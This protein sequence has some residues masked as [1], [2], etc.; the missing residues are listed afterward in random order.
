MIQKTLCD[1]FFPYDFSFYCHWCTSFLSL[2][3]FPLASTLQDFGLWCWAGS[4]LALSDPG[5][6]PVCLGSCDVLNRC[7]GS[8]LMLGSASCLSHAGTPCPTAWGCS[9]R[10][11]LAE[12]KAWGMTWSE[13]GLLSGAAAGS[14]G[15][16]Q[17]RSCRS[18][19]RLNCCM[20]GRGKSKLKQQLKR[21]EQSS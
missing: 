5:A 6:Y 18:N 15:G 21:T 7:C 17:Q 3:C 9:S 13:L 11:L 14:Q 1:S 16:M 10:P 12:S 20:P 2:C 8:A 4:G 19:W